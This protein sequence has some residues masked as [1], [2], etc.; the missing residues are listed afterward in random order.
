M[1]VS[2]ALKAEE[3]ELLRELA[4]NNAETAR[5]VLKVAELHVVFLGDKVLTEID[6]ERLVELKSKYEGAKSLLIELQRV[7][8]RE[9]GRL[10]NT[11]K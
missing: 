8:V 4:V 10:S 3:I 7:L 11:P 9:R 2:N 1:M 5:A 6:N